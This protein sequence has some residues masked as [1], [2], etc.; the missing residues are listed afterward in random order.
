MLTA[1][2]DGRLTRSRPYGHID[3]P[4]RA[5]FDLIGPEPSRFYA[6]LI[7]QALRFGLPARR[8]LGPLVAFLGR[9]DIPQ[10]PLAAALRAA[11]RRAPR[12]ELD[13]LVHSLTEAWPRLAAVAEG[14]NETPPQLSALALERR[15]ALT[16][17]AFGEHSNPLLVLKV[18][19]PNSAGVERELHA[20]R[21]AAPAAISP[22][23]FGPVAD[24]WAQE[25]LAGAPLRVEPLSPAAARGLAWTPDLDELGRAL[26]RLA[27][28]TTHRRPP[29]DLVVP[30]ER[31][32]AHGRMPDATHRLATAAWRD[33][34][35]L[36]VS[37]LRHG[38]TSPQ[39]CL[40]SGGRLTGLVDWEDAAP[41]GAPGWD[42][43]NVA[44]AYLDHGVGLRR[45]S[46][47]LVLECFTHA[48]TGA[49]GRGARDAARAAARA[50]AVPEQLLDPLELCV[51]AW[52]VGRRLANP[53]F[54][55]TSASTAA[56]MLEVAAHA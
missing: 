28:V 19:S 33:V 54:Y 6:A 52:R 12:P 8:R 2:A 46:Q 53:S 32:L 1:T 9:S 31:A 50:A 5:A 10:A 22:R 38:D 13:R 27:E 29:D 15:S 48:W 43:L 23:I 26:T 56:R 3:Y 49:F 11:A 18:P 47:P 21:L 45:W 42:T 37:V 7:T 17:F 51:F 55:P 39:N 40:F 14:L 35:R 25:A 41:H 16:V 4:W 36:E 44:L 20:L 30:I 24:G 34:R